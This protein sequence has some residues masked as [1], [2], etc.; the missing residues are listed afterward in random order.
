MSSPAAAVKEARA[1]IA[2]SR[3]ADARAA[4]D[5]ALPSDAS[6]FTLLALAGYACTQAS[7]V[8]EDEEGVDS[9]PIVPVHFPPR[10]SSVCRSHI[11]SFSLPPLPDRLFAV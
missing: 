1:A 8:R 5:A 9:P 2:A 3:W 6:N 11:H 4:V 10:F 7:Q